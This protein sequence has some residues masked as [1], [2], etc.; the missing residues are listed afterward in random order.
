LADQSARLDPELATTRSRGP[1]R[2]PQFRFCPTQARPKAPQR[3]IRNMS[4]TILTVKVGYDIGRAIRRD[5]CVVDPQ[6]ME[7]V[8]LDIATLSDQELEWVGLAIDPNGSGLLNQLYCTEDSLCR[9]ETR[10]L[11]VWPVTP[12]GVFEALARNQQRWLGC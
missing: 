3:K 12:A 11:R 6:A 2:A 5:R 8:E 4:P 7:A 9:D 1:S 10:A